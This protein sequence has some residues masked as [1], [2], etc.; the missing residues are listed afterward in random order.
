MVPPPVGGFGIAVE[1]EGLCAIMSVMRR[2]KLALLPD[3]DRKLRVAL[4]R[5]QRRL[6][7]LLGDKVVAGMVI[8]SVA[9]GCA[10]DASDV[11]VVLFLRDG[12]PRRGHYRWW[13]RAV[14]PHLGSWG[15]CVQPIFVALSSRRTSEPSLASALRRGILLWDRSRL[16]AGRKLWSTGS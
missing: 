4:T 16:F 13:D 12:G 14:V 9:E 1:P 15:T 11:D 3:N 8:G 10:R 5:A 7:Q 2:R 6:P